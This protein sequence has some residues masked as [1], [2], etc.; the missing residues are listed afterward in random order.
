M[1]WIRTLISVIA[2]TVL[3]L[4][5]FV[6]VR[7]VILS[8][9]LEPIVVAIVPAVLSRNAMVSAILSIINSFLA[10]FVTLAILGFPDN[11]VGYLEFLSYYISSF[12]LIYYILTSLTWG[13][14]FWHASHFK[15]FS[16]KD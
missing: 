15:N 8:A 3:G 5:A 1:K 16:N 6:E 2:G 14:I 11:L 4:I 10:L 9:I 7:N 13:V 12:I